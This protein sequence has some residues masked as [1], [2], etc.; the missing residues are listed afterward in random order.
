MCPQYFLSNCVQLPCF[1]LLALCFEPKGDDVAFPYFW[2]KQ[3]PQV[4]LG[5]VF[6]KITQGKR[7]S[8]CNCICTLHPRHIWLESKD[9]TETVGCLSPSLTP[10]TIHSSAIPMYWIDWHLKC[11]T[12][13]LKS[14]LSFRSQ[15]RLNG[16]YQPV[17]GYLDCDFGWKTHLLWYILLSVAVVLHHPLFLTIYLLLEMQKNELL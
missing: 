16:N 14:F 4:N 2:F 5:Q 10:D 13:S 3:R 17:L 7:Q 1:A 12:T 11:Y 6:I 9:E 8:H 15:Y